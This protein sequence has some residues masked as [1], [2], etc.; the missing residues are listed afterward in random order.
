MT[1]S[2]THYRIESRVLSAL[3]CV[4]MMRSMV[5]PA[6]LILGEERSMIGVISRLAAYPHL[7]AYTWLSLA[8]LVVP[9]VLI[10]VFRPDVKCRDRIVRM[11]SFAASAGGVL[12]FFLAYLSRNLD[13]PTAVWI[14]SGNGLSGIGLGAVLAYTLNNTQIRRAQE[15]PENEP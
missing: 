11:A 1:L 10:Q 2:L 14:C 7:L 6:L 15:D 8:V 5:D 4:V 12:W 13:Y 9:Y 3:L